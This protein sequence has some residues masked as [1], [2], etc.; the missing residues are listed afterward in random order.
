MRY[1]LT[2]HSDAVGQWRC[3][4]T[5]RLPAFRSGRPDDLP[6]ALNDSPALTLDWLL[7]RR[8]FGAFTAQAGAGQHGGERI[9]VHV[10]DPQA[11]I[12]GEGHDYYGAWLDMF[13]QQNRPIGWIAAQRIPGALADLA[14][15]AARP[16]EARNAA[17]QDSLDRLRGHQPREAPAP[18][19]L[20]AR[21]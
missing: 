13:R 2:F 4:D 6:R 9:G 11:G 5:A 1:L 20:P 18:K 17:C 15:R 3:L 16:F 12:I 10:L 7:G 21:L 14:A 8:R 19:P